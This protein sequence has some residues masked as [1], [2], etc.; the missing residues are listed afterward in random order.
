[1]KRLI[2][3]NYTFVVEFANK[4][5]DNQSRVSGADLSKKKRALLSFD[6]KKRLLAPNKGQKQF[7]SSLSLS[8]SLRYVITLCCC[9]PG[10]SYS[11]ELYHTI[12]THVGNRVM[13]CV[14]YFGR[15][16]ER[17]ARS[18][19]SRAETGRKTGVSSIRM[20]I[21]PHQSNSAILDL[22]TFLLC[23]R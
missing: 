1:V 7:F 2:F 12:L 13:T 21:A 8:L 4:L 20:G 23:T 5:C 6:F 19:R 9:F 17:G 3:K 15:A 10:A 14:L 16:S 11:L 18:N 22:A